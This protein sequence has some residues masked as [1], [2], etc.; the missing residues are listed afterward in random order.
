MFR[1][2]VLLIFSIIS[3]VLTVVRRPAKAVAAGLEPRVTAI[4]GSYLLLVIPLLP[5]T[6]VGP[7]WSQVAVWVMA[8]GLCFCIYSLVWLGRSYSIMASARK[9]VTAGPYSVVRHPLYMCELTMLLG[10][11]IAG[12][13]I[14]SVLIAVATAALLYRRMINEERILSAAFPDYADY[15]RRVPRVFPRL[16]RAKPSVVE[17]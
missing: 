13:S 7:F 17:A 6:D 11:T 5:A 10:V 15:A 1:T 14:W 9:L 12:F 3:A 2:S 16:F 4:L 8:F